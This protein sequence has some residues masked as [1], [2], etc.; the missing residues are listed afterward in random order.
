M[1][2][3]NAAYTLQDS[4]VFQELDRHELV[5]AVRFCKADGYAMLKAD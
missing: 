2:D 4:K 5:T 1:V 3:A